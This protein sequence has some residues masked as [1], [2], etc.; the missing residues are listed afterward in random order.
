MAEFTIAVDRRF[1][2]E[3]QSAD[4]FRVKTWG[5]TADYVYD[6]LTKGRLVAIDGR[7]ESRKYTDREGVNREIFEV[8]ADNVN[9]LDRPK[10]DGHAGNQSEPRQTTKIDTEYDPFA[11]E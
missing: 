7:F 6:Y 11:D 5:R 1:N 2:R 10:D 4:F 9:A 3:E 8:V